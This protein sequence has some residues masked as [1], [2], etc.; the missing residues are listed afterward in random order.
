MPIPRNE[1]AA[2]SSMAWAISSVATTITL[3]A[4]FGRTTAEQDPGARRAHELGGTDE[5][6]ARDL[7]RGRPRHHR[8]T[9]P[10]QQTEHD[11]HDGERIAGERHERQRDQDER[12]GEP[13]GDQEGDRRIR[14]AAQTAGEQAEAD[15]DDSGDRPPRRSR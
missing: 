2:S 5:L 12:Q 4:T 15:A 13:D 9:V 11:H 14:P 1:S 7:L 3:L 10:H 6:A 8:E